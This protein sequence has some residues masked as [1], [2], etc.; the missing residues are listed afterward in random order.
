MIAS[1]GNL[2][3]GVHREQIGDISLG[4]LPAGSWRN[5]TP[6]EVEHLWS[7]KPLS[8]CSNTFQ[9]SSKPLTPSLS[10]KKRMRK[11]HKARKAMKESDSD[12][13]SEEAMASTQNQKSPD[14]KIK[15]TKKTKPI[16]K[17]N[18]TKRPKPS[19][20]KKGAGAVFS[21]PRGFA[22]NTK[23][24]KSFELPTNRSKPKRPEPEFD[25]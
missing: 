2:S 23:Q 24:S 6:A 3:L 21:P 22:K 14:S 17:P 1:V 19:D 5:L 10:P 13:L 20:K 25:F 4:D 8:Q 16:K 11:Y 7:K 12:V 15:P 18:P 9:L